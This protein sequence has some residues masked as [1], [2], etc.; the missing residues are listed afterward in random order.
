MK[1]DLISYLPDVLLE[2]YEFPLL[3]LTEQPEFDRFFQAS[4]EVLDC[5]FVLTAPEKG[6]AR[7]ERIFGITAKDT[8][9]LEERR[10]RI[11]ERLNERLPYTIR[12]LREMLD[13]LY[14][15]GACTVEADHANYRLTVTFDVSKKSSFHE[16]LFLRVLP[17]NLLLEL[18]LRSPAFS[19]Y[20]GFLVS[21]SADHVYCMASAPDFRVREGRIYGGFAVRESTLQRYEMRGDG[22]V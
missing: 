18:S 5:Q 15:E 3:C 10:L 1:K 4:D 8:E 7:Y 21:E 2:T 16:D 13:S 12:R 11:L 17:A 14:G 20:A 19:I 9:S 6:V 22:Y